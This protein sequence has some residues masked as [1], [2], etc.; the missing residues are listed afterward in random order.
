M[1][2]KRR[3]RRTGRESR[4]KALRGLRMPRWLLP[5]LVFVAVGFLYYRP[6]TTYLETRQQLPSD[7]R[8]SRR[9]APSAAG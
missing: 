4:V 2:G 6:I 8:R 5:V 7:A 9:C 3:R 1:A